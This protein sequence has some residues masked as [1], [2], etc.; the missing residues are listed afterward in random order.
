LLTSGGGP[1][2]ESITKNQIDLIKE[3]N[4]LF[5]DTPTIAVEHIPSTTEDFSYHRNDC[6]RGLVVDTAVSPLSNTSAKIVEALADN[7]NMHFLAVGHNHGYDYCCPYDSVKSENNLH[8][9]FGRHSGYGG[10][11]TWD[12]GARVYKLEYESSFDEID[13]KNWIFR[14]SSYIRMESGKTIHEYDPMQPPT[15]EALSDKTMN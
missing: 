12:R 9:C 1:L 2:F 7:Q 15:T 5:S 13:I 3:T 4:T 6:S 14:W 10:Y 8:L 11:G